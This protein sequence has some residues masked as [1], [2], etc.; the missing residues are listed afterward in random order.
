MEHHGKLTSQIPMAEQAF[1]AAVSLNTSRCPTWISSLVT[2]GK[3]VVLMKG[4]LK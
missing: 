1:L 2:K 3:A 4:D